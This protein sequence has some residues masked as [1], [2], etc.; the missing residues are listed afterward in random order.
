MFP[1]SKIALKYASPLF[2]TGFRMTLAGIMLLGYQYLFKKEHFVF[3]TGYWKPLLF[4]AFVNIYV[5]NVLCYWG[6]HY[7]TPTKSCFLYNLYPFAAAFIAY[8]YLNERLTPYKWLGLCIGF[9]GTVPLLF[10]SESGGAMHT[11]WHFFIPLPEL[12]IVV[13]II[14]DPLG[15]IFIQKAILHNKCNALMANGLTMFFGGIF[16]LFHSASVEGWSPL[17]IV[18]YKGF[19]LSALALMLISNIVGS[20][21]YIKL[22]QKYSITFLALSSFIEPLLVGIFDWFLFSLTVPKSF[23]PSFLVVCLGLYVFYKDELAA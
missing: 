2:L 18:N 14:T 6:A 7:V 16:A 13:S 17:P 20:V 3:P 8:M 19:L 21:V 11:G 1:F 15:W 23:Y 12:A 22:L 4:A 5:T 10:T 9:L